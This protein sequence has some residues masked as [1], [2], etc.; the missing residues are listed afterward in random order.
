MSSVE[1]A[2][3][4]AAQVCGECMPSSCEAFQLSSPFMMSFIESRQSHNA[5]GSNKVRSPS[6]ASS[7]EAKR[8]PTAIS[9][10]KGSG[11]VSRNGIVHHSGDPRNAAFLFDMNQ[12]I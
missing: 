12:T 2:R 3:S 10:C 6:I 9:D 8:A 1:I 7:A 11:G 5:L 4:S